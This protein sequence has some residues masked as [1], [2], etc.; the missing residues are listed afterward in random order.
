MREIKYK[1][2]DLTNNLM[3]YSNGASSF[4][5][6]DSSD[7]QINRN[8][9]KSVMTWNGAVYSEGTLLNLIMLQYINLKTGL[10]NP[11][12]IY[13]KD[14]LKYDDKVW[15]VCYD[16]EGA[17]FILQRTLFEFGESAEIH[18]NYDVAIESDHFGNF[19]LNPE[20]IKSEKVKH[21]KPNSEKKHDSII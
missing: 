14:L 5:G 9:I 15:Q 19:Y 8:D 12:E 18:L 7:G 6:C 21:I 13:E 4:H 11:V 3:L 1:A 2:W 10:S 16:S 20:V 17:R